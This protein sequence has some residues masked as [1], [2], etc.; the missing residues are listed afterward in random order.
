MQENPVARG[1]V[2][3]AALQGSACSSQPAGT[4]SH[5]DTEPG[6]GFKGPC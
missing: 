2:G 5:C 3:V 6:P 4:Q 1:S